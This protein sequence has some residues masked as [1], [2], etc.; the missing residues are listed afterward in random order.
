MNRRAATQYNPANPRF[1]PFGGMYHG[2]ATSNAAVDCL[3]GVDDVAPVASVCD[4]S[5]ATFQ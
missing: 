2:I 1:G 4:T 3:F 5:T